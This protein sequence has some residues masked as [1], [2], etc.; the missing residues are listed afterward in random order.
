[1]KKLIFFLSVLLAMLGTVAILLHFEVIG[2]KTGTLPVQTTTLPPTTEPVT[3]P[4]TQAPTTE[5]PT[6]EPPTTTEPAPVIEDSGK[7]T[8]TAGLKEHF[9]LTDGYKD[10]EVTVLE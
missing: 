9:S 3:E 2:T 1:M 6:T 10:R 4:T 7:I 5:P 8:I